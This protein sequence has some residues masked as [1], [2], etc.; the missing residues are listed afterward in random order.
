MLL[1]FPIPGAVQNPEK[2]VEDEVAVMRF[3]QENTSIPIPQYYM[4]GIASHEFEGL[5]PFFS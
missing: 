1:R 5:G 4:H 2:N 3:I